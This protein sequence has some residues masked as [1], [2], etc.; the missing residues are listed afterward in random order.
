LGTPRIGKN[1]PP[2]RSKG[3]FSS[4]KLIL[5][6]NWFYQLVKPYDIVHS[7]FYFRLFLLRRPGSKHIVTLHDMIP[8]DFP[9]HFTDHNPHFQ[10]ASFLRDAD[11][12][13]CVSK[14]TMGR[15]EHHYPELVHK[16]RV[17]SPGV[18][19]PA[20]KNLQIKRDC[21]ILFVGQRGGYKDFNT[22]LRSIPPL[23]ELEPNL[24][25]LAVGTDIFSTS[26]LSLISELGIGDRVVQKELSDQELE[27]AY[28][29]CLFVCV[30]SHVEGFGLPVIEAMSHGALVIATDI[31]V[32][33]EIANDAFLSFA[34]G[35]S[36][37]L[38]SAIRR[39]LVD[40]S[41]F[42]VYREKGLSIASGYTWANTLNSLVTLYEEVGFASR[43]V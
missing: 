24:E 41:A 35:D 36:A 37:Q 23:I 33:N 30:T 22:L 27:K 16:A 28:E 5:V 14:Y 43:K 8:E 31:P 38:T 11:A 9:M 18:T 3:I 32:F 42:E 40:P 2:F 6:I 29:T 17:I 21:T 10:K 34:P 1:G 26:E 15:L 20:K 12:I 4:K 19:M 39:V 7:T 13:V 25:V